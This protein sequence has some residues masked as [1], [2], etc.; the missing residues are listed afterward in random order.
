MSAFRIPK[1]CIKEID[2]LCSAFLWSGPALNPNKPKVCWDDVCKLKGEGG[3]GLKSLEEANT[4][5][6]LKL[7]WRIL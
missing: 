5:C 6:C 1:K 7:I 3:L 4:V 2:K